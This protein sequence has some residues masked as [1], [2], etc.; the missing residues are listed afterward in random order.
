M[1]DHKGG[2]AFQVDTVN[3][4]AYWD[5]ALS[6]E[7]CKQIIKLGESKIVKK[8]TIE[9]KEED[10]QIRDS[11][12]SWIYPS[13]AIWLYE[14]LT[15][16]AENLNNQFFNFNLFGMIEGIQFTK[17]TAPSGFYGMHMDKVFNGA[18][19]KLSISVQLS[20][21][22]E[23]EGGELLLYTKANPDVMGKEQGKLVAFP[24][25]ILHEVKPVTKGKRYSLVVWITGEQFK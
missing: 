20:D 5:G 15:L 18:A 23:Y 19:R 17:Y 13:D 24:S 22:K 2:W 14:R 11:E 12:V 10:K 4:W 3:N 6:K 9:N 8:A 7:E 21:E 1:S 16:I 25:Y